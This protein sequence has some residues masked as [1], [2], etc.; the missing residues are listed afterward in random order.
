MPA[1]RLVFG[2]LALAILIGGL[3]TPVQAIQSVCGIDSQTGEVVVLFYE[4]STGEIVGEI[5]CSSGCSC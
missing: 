1:R 5:R 4:E 2:F 3:L